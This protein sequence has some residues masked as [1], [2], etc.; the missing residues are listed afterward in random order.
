ME[1]F[2]YRLTS[3]CKR[4]PLGSPPRPDR[5]KAIA[6]RRDAGWYLERALAEP[7]DAIARAGGDIGAT[8]RPRLATAINQE[9]PLRHYPTMLLTRVDIR[10][11]HHVDKIWC[12]ANA[13]FR[14]LLESR[15][16]SAKALTFELLVEPQR[17]FARVALAAVAQRPDL[18]D[19]SDA[20]LLEAA[21][22]DDANTTRYEFRRALAALWSTAS[23][24]AQE[25]VLRYA[26]SAEEAVEISER[27]A[28]DKVPDYPSA[29]ELRRQWRSQLL[30]RIREAIPVEW[31]ERI[32]PLDLLEDDGPLEPRV[33]TWSP[34]SPVT[35][36]ELA[37]MEPEAVIGVL[38]RWATA[39][40]SRFDAPGPEGL[41]VAV[42]GA[43]VSRLQEFSLMGPVVAN[44][45]PR[46]VTAITSAIER[47]LREDQ[48]HDH[49]SAVTFTLGIGEALLLGAR[50]NQ[51]ST[52][53]RRNIA[54]IIAM[55]SSRN[56]LNHT[57]SAAAMELL[58]LLLQD[59]DPT[60]QSEEGDA[61]SR[62]DVGMLALNSVRGAATTAMI[63]LLLQL[64]RAERAELAD[65]TA[66]ILRALIGADDS[67]SVRAAVGIRLP[68]LLDKDG[69]Y[70]SQWL[71]IL[72]GAG[73]PPTAREATWDAYLLFSRFFLDTASFLA[74]QYGTA[75]SS[76]ADR[77][78][79]DRRLSRDRDERL[80]IH[81]AM[82]H[83]FEL[84]AEAHGQWLSKFYE[85][86]ADWLRARVTRWVAEQAATHDA[87]PAMRERARAVLRD[88]IG[89][90]NDVLQAEELRA[91]GWVARTPDFEV[92][93]LEGIVL[94]ALER[95]GGA[96]DDETGVA[97]LVAR[98]STTKPM[99][100]A[101]A[102][103]L[104]VSGDTWH[105]LPHIAGN[106]LRQAL[107]VLAVGDDAEARTIS[108]GI[109]HT[110]GA[111]GFPEY[112]DLLGGDERD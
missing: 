20:V 26:E 17:T 21:R 74:D 103:R 82:A 16:E 99:V 58:R 105:A 89:R 49:A 28:A 62:H 4:H 47:G 44:V 15:L 96:T 14:V 86:A 45:H 81:V 25:A 59:I 110:L 43:V 91:I 75:I 1:D 24:D 64:R 53:A 9:G 19:K 31:L 100:A 52:E 5:V 55:G 61:A 22:F 57:E 7:I 76:L 66:A 37:A 73:V 88:R 56:V 60:P 111:L 46:F 69:D 48:I 92:E 42:A 18:L 109:V 107:A 98:C 51:S 27:L 97:D 94:P 77:G 83:L 65:E 13:L 84:P 10:P 87:A 79:D 90:G 85:R 39:D 71:D 72:F 30:F 40:T 38:D 2:H 68:W 63:E 3:V 108:H 102:L 54:E 36:D 67:R 35:E 6:S 78:Q 101:K 41:A 50:P 70:R 80:G 95:T 104:L 34:K 33:E 93:V 106:N 112:R 11:R 23:V 12:L 32:G 29:N 8:L